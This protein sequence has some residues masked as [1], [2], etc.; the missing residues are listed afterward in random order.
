MG[1]ELIKM[2][3]ELFHEL[4][5]GFE[6]DP[7]MFA[8]AAEYEKYR[9]YEY[10]PDKVDAHF[11]RR[12]S[13]VDRLSFAVMFDGS[14]IGEVVLKHIDLNAKRCEL[15][16][17]LIND[18]V[19]N[20]GRGTEAERLAIRYA[21]EELGMEAVYADSLVKNARSRHI[22]E[23]LGFEFLYENAGFRYY[24]LD[25]ASFIG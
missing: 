11:D 4:Y 9:N 12:S 6:Y 10:N 8:D 22:M 23:K 15:G 3:R 17:H 25:K 7:I 18:S 2:T 24:R 1:V 20:K 14:V 16:I 13:E 19:K 21:F 5:R